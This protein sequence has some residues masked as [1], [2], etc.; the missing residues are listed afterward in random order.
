MEC[1]S[2]G[3]LEC[4]SAGVMVTNGIMK[5]VYFQKECL[6]VKIDRAHR[7]QVVRFRVQSSG[8]KTA[9]HPILMGY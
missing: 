4:W 6:P 8:L 3:V 5:I 9:N 1:W 2:A 7:T